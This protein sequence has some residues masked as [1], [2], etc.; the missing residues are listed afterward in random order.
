[1]DLRELGEFGLIAAL[2]RRAARLSP[3]WALGIGDDAAL[4][5]PR[6]GFELALT[7]DA[8]V[9]DVHFR[10]RTADARALGRKALRVNLSDLG[11]MG[12]RPLGFLLSLGLPPDTPAARLSGFFAGL[13]AEAREAGCPLVGGDT[14][15]APLW[16][17]SISALGEVAHGRALRRSALRPG[18]RLMVTG[19]LGASALG[20]HLLETGHL[21]DPRARR[22]ARRHQLPPRRHRI[23]AAL[24]A[25][26]LSRAALDVSDGLAQD[27]A[28]LCEASRVAA[29]VHLDALPLAPGF[30]DLCQREGLDA[31]RLAAAGGEDYELLFAVA[32]DAPAAGQLA[33]RLGVRVT[34]IGRARRGRGI[35]WFSAAKRVAGP[36]DA[37]FAHFKPR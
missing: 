18:D 24:T 23:G 28:H 3:A 29:D 20:L 32:R 4:L 26:R 2:R 37:G 14:V 36:T 31:A 8:L 33:R 9:E 6:R 21:R 7:V 27:L 30:A 5:R 10:W 25:A 13:L 16:S 15:R 35:R 17:L 12:A 22:F 19:E 34:E 11:A 1:V